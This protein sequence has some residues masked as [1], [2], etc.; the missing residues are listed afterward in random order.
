MPK[1][2][3][4]ICAYNRSESVVEL[5]KCLLLQET[6]CPYEVI[7]VDN[8]STDNTREVVESCIPQ[9]SGRLRCF[10][11]R[12]QG[13]SFALNLGIKES[14]GEI[15]AF[16]D[17]DCLVKKDYVTQVH[18]VFQEYGD[19]IDFFGGKILPHWVGGNCPAWLNEIIFD[20]TK[21]A[22][23]DER[24]W[25]R[26]FF[27]G[28]LAFLDYG[29]TPFRVD[30]S[31]KQYKD[32]LFYGPNMAVKKSALEKI[33]GYALDRTITQDTEI[34]LR[35]I[36]TGMKGLYTPHVEVEHKVQVAKINPGFY[37]QWYLKRGKFLEMRDAV[38]KKFYYPLG[39]PIHFIF[40]TGI[41]YLKS[42]TTKS[43]RDKVYFRS[44]A[45]FNLTQIIKIAQ[46]NIV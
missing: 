43:L 32:F 5:L 18:Q 16:L 36:R 41:L 27:R 22:T 21:Y 14:R 9:F 34:C 31:L 39:I 13:K 37:Y 33:G 30:S 38:Q 42:M 10:L 12:R 23:D 45:L 3:V 44:Q 28:P 46:K 29:D 26:V 8:N 7:V 19:G 6:D 15:L 1:I 35:L 17:D 2:S 40:K 11:E 20:E 24:Y 4:I 25:R